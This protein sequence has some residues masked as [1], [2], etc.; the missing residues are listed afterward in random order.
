[1]SRLA[2]PSPLAISPLTMFEEKY[3]GWLIEILTD[4][5][6]YIFNCW[7]PGCRL[8]VSDRQ[9]YPTLFSARMAAKRRA[10][11]E[12][13]KWALQHCYQ[14]YCQG[15]LNSEEFQTLEELINQT[16]LSNLEANLEQRV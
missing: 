9:N 16:L 1:M 3:H 8:A 11:R 13:V 15:N 10:D 6:G 7:L 14:T 12:S 2:C 4:A 5:E